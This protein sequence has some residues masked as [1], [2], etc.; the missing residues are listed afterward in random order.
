[1]VLSSKHL[2]TVSDVHQAPVISIKFFGDVS[3]TQK[4]ISVVSSD[5]EGIVYL[6]YY[7][8]GILSY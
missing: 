3:F 2:K 4:K 7:Q 5:L 6:S 1:M 8:E